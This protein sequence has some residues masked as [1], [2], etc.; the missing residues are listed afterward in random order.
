MSGTEL[1]HTK[2]G[3]SRQAA[4][5]TGSTSHGHT[6]GAAVPQGQTQG[7]GSILQ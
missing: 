7:N 1:L 6:W 5:S 4:H 3:V 2:T